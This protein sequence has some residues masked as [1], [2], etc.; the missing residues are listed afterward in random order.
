MTLLHRPLGGGLTVDPSTTVP[1]DDL[2]TGLSAGAERVVAISAPAGY[3]KTTAVA[4]W[5]AVDERPFVWARFGP[6]D[7]DPE[8]LIGRILEAIDDARPYHQPM[9]SGFTEESSDVAVLRLLTRV[10]AGG[11][12]VLVLDGLHNV[13]QAGAEIIDLI[14]DALPQRGRIVLIGRSLGSLRLA[15]RRLAGDVTDLGIDE[16]VLSHIEADQLLARLGVDPARRDPLREMGDGWAAG[17]ALLGRGNGSDPVTAYVDEEVLADLPEEAVHLLECAALLDDLSPDSLDSAI[18]QPDATRRLRELDRSGAVPIRRGAHDRASDLPGWRCHPLVSSV[19]RSRLEQRDRTE[20][21][22]LHQRASLLGEQN[23]DVVVAVQ[24]AMDAGD[25]ARAAN[26]VLGHVPRLLPSGEVDDLVDLTNRLGE[27][28]EEAHAAAALALGWRALG[29]GDPPMLGRALSALAGHL[30]ASGSPPHLTAA[31]A[32]LR[33]MLAPDGLAGV[34]EDTEVARRVGDAGSNPWW[35]IATFAQGATYYV[36]DQSDRASVL[37]ASVYPHIA[38][39]PGLGAVTLSYLALLDL[40]ADDAPTARR[41]LTEA[42]RLLDRHRLDRAM[43]LVPAFAIGARVAALVGQPE[44]ARTRTA[45]TSAMIATIDP[46]A[47]RTGLLCGL[48]LGEASL[49]LGDRAGA[50]RYAHDAVAARRLD[51]SATRLNRELDQLLL[52]L[53]SGDDQIGHDSDQLT[54]AEMRVLAYL[55]THLSLQ[56]I[57]DELLISRNT[58]KSHSVAIYR[59]LRAAKRSEAVETARQQGILPA[60]PT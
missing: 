34:L 39:S 51:S 36:L 33:A 28:A 40:D 47:P 18:E 59:K 20:A 49:H 57:A 46:L 17:L 1:R 48:C 43:L 30:P 35:A 31:M 13:S 19:L 21:R 5:D 8:V 25:T 32:T 38:D 55:P 56:G 4:L 58:A 6:R 60:S 53:E 10:E 3:G 27:G 9:P 45:Q 44:L 24:H 16:L 15:R 2:V 52:R 11:P 22:R 41:R 7:D 42:S 12:I 14:V 37:F 26:L 23:G 54:P 50:R 29:V